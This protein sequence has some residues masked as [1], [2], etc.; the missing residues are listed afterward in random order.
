MTKT[1]ADYAPHLI[2][3]DKYNGKQMLYVETTRGQPERK[4]V[5]TSATDAKGRKLS[6]RITVTPTTHTAPPEGHD[7]HWLR[8]IEKGYGDFATVCVQLL[9]DGKPFG[10]SQRDEEFATVAEAWAHGEKLA[11]KRKAAAERKAK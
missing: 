5:E 6:F 3:T 9:K 11:A 4:T 10:A 1:A 7:C 8:S 2:F